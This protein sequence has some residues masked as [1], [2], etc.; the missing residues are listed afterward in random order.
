MPFQ[1]GNKLG[2]NSKVIQYEL[3][4]L[5]VQE[6]WVRLRAGLNTLLNNIRDGDLDSLV[7]ARDSID[8]RPKQ[9]VDI[10]ADETITEGLPL[11][12]AFLAAT[13]AGSADGDYQGVGQV[14]SMVPPPVS[15]E[16]H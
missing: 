11:F 3:R 8:G 10:T 1:K 14:G 7:F 13:A 16:T 9:Q 6:D 4:K 5:C 2:E 15:V 12:A